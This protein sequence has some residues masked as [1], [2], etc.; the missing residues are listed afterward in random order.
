MKLRV[1]GISYHLK[2][3]NE[4]PEL[5]D[6][7]FLHG[8]MG[9]GENFKAL[10]SKCVYFCN[11]LT[12]DLL[13]HGETEGAE[14][15]YRF[16]HKEQTADL[17]KLI[18]EQI[19]RPVFLYGYSMGARL[20]LSLALKHPELFYGLILESGTFGIEGETERQARQSLDGRRADEILGNFKGFL[21]EWKK[22]ELLKTNEPHPETEMIQ[23]QQQ[24]LWIAN[25]LLGFGT[26]TMP[27][28]RNALPDLP[29][30]VQLITGQKD[31]KFIRI[32]QV[33]KKELNSA[34][35]S[36]VQN[37]GHRVHLDQPDEIAKIL[38]SFISKHFRHELDHR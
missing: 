32:N 34:E 33:M 13:G 4:E 25:S 3:W 35:L 23:S 17:K 12:I 30:P 11:P 24:P 9:S 18:S 6:V 19:G 37:A 8:F 15:H 21:D 5:P 7:V 22:L 10:V 20:A 31:S 27:C 26:G 36:I 16:S 14:L 2:R 1:R 38:R 28:F 29:L